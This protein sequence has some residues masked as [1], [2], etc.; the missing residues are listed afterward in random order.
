[1]T[2][3]TPRTTIEE[4]APVVTLVNVFTVEPHR[5]AELI[6]LLD[7][8]TEEVM[9][10][11]PGFVAANIHR[12]LE[13]TRVANYAQWESVEAF[14]AMLA[15]PTARTHMEEAL[16]MAEAAPAL[17]EVS[18]VHRADAG[19]ETTSARAQLD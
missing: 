18:S 7:R 6:E 17:Y 13:G 16:A 3:T 8:A 4:G 19:C 11:R 5:Q 12:G 2:A 9:R 10:H 14:R 15:D 1:M